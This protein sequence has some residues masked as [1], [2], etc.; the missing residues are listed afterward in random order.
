MVNPKASVPEAVSASLYSLASSLER[1]GMLHQSLD[2]YLKLVELYPASKE[3]ALA[4]QQLLTIVE[5]LRR[6]GQYHLAM[7]VLNRLEAAHQSQE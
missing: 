7:T 3:A 6:N 1:S 2:P 5:N 4:A